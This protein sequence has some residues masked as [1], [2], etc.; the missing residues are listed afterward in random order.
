MFIKEG[1][2]KHIH[3]FLLLITIV[4]FIAHY[5]L[6]EKR[7]L[8]DPLAN[9]SVYSLYGYIDPQQGQ[10]SY[11]L[12]E[13]KNLWACNY[14][15][16]HLYGCGSSIEWNE[17]LKDAKDF[18]K[19]E[20]LELKLKYVGSAKRL[21]LSLRSYNK[22][23]SEQGVAE[24]N[25][26]MYVLLPTSEIAENKVRVKL[27]EFSVSKWWVLENSIPRKW[28]SPEFNNITSLGVE[29]AEHGDQIVQVERVELVG[30]WVET[31]AIL[32][33]LIL[34]WMIVFLVD[35][36]F[37]F[38]Q[39]YQS[40]QLGMVRVK[41]LLSQQ[42]N[43]EVER[44]YLRS[45]AKKDPLTGVYN[46]SGLESQLNA[47][48]GEDIKRKYVAVMIMDLDHFKAINDCYGHDFGDAV[49]KAFASSMSKSI[50][51]TDIFARWGGEEFI[52]I[53]DLDSKESIKELAEKLREATVATPVESK[54]RFKFTVSI[55]VAIS[56]ENENF[57]EV[58]KRA[59]SAMFKAKKNGRNRVE[60]EL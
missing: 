26:H 42:Q 19:F 33:I 38:Y 2:S 22:A 6:P 46:R 28:A 45:I 14:K 49:L 18:S 47:F 8:L 23:Y 9:K 39:V 27:S 59:D 31:E 52:L 25:K 11:W 36:A 37:R 48:F 3:S 34:F 24:T 35:G 44:Q 57:T 54:P 15:P 60:Y 51:E 40:S 4:V 55:G 20:A 32:Y 7:I 30:K 21:R 58:F 41:E 53:G 29:V 56:R 10:S 13:S 17:R 1:M 12:D 50:R 5:F 43:L 16:E